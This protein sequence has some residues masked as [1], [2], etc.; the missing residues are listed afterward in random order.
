MCVL[1]PPLMC[2]LLPAL[3]ASRYDEAEELLLTALA[4]REASFGR[5]HPKVAT[6]LNNLATLYRDNSR[7]GAGGG[8]VCVCTC[9][10]GAGIYAPVCVSS[11]PNPVLFLVPIHRQL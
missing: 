4:A 6:T 7:W 10:R 3:P 2:V 5:E 8:A 1:L 11:V 9:V